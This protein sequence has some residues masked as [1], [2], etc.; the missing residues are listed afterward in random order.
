MP[1]IAR[2]VAEFEVPALY[3]THSAEELTF[4]ADR[5]ISIRDGE[6]CGWSE[7]APRLLGRVIQADD[8]GLDLAIGDISVRVVG[9]GR[10]GEIWALLLGNDCL[11]STESPGVS[12]ACLTLQARVVEAVKGSDQCILEVENQRV[13]LK[14]RGREVSLPEAH[15]TVWLS[16]Q[17]ILARPVHSS[18]TWPD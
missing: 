1:Y 3:V 13:D 14:W 12:N 10:P 4:L 18:T 5:T 16:L 7:V 6:L 17:R 2:A 11:V 8:N 15:T 9:Q